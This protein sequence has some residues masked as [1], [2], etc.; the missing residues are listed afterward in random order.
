MSGMRIENKEHTIAGTPA[1]LNVHVDDP[2]L[3][4]EYSCSVL[5]VPGTQMNR[6]KVPASD[7]LSAR[8]HPLPRSE[9]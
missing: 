8:C 3:G 2:S 9:V 4:D 6:F 1:S 7:L 5:F